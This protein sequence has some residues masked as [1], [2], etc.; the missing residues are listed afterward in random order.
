MQF[1][2][3]TTGLLLI[4][5]LALLLFF[6]KTIYTYNLPEVTGTR[7]FRGSLD[8][9]ELSSGT[10]D[11]GD[12][13][14]IYAAV[15]GIVGTVAVKEGDRVGK[16]QELFRMEYK[17]E[18]V[19]RKLQELENNMEKLRI[20]IRNTQLKL[21]RIDKAL[22]GTE[23]VEQDAAVR[24]EPNLIGLEIMKA[25]NALA[26]AEFALEYGGISKNDLLAARTNVQSLL[27]KYEAER[28]DLQFSLDMKNTDMQNLM[29]EAKSSLG[30]LSDFRTYAAI[31]AP[32]DGI[33][34]SLNVKKGM[35]IGENVP[36][37]SIGAGNTFT[38]DCTVSTD[39]NF[40]TPGDTCR[41]YNASR[42]V[43]GVVSRVQPS[44]GGKAVRVSVVSDGIS[45]GES[46]E[47]Q[48]EKQSAALFTMV[49]NGALNQDND[50]YFLYQIKRT[51]GIM[52]EEYYIERLNVYIGDSDYQNTVVIKGISFFEPIVLLGNK[53]LAAGDRIFLKN[54]GDFFEN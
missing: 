48:F 23:S 10:A 50:G 36:M 3:R 46:F 53:P 6:S 19:E 14:T 32:V 18:S 17:A 30:M 54:A 9:L 2:K 35:Y 8:K 11:Y 25:R 1:N 15:S 38:I 28:I 21:E 12:L 40:I 34:Q 41:L 26:D 16:G 45:A 33:V 7:P 52:G 39:N 22:R 44:T 5:V 51:K 31:T 4:A 29:I 37:V 42:E 43:T 20:D 47:V 27:L 24:D 13:E 49:P